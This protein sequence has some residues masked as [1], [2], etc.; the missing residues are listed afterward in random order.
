MHPRWRRCSSLK[1]SRYSRS[2]RLA[3]GAPRP[4]RCDARLSPRAAGHPSELAP[5]HCTRGNRPQKG[6]WQRTRVQTWPQR[7]GFD[8]RCSRFGSWGGRRAR[9]GQTPVALH[10]AGDRPTVPPFPRRRERWPPSG[11]T[12]VF[13]GFA[14]PSPTGRFRLPEGKSRL[15]GLLIFAL[16]FCFLPSRRA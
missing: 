10:T 8:T 6:S 9:P 12:A 5:P 3:S 16:P 4:S 2:S 15:S 13:V 14:P 11:M 1:Y 7:S